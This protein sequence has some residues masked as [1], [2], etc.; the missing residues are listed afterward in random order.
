MMFSIVIPIYN[1]KKYLSKCLDSILCQIY[2]DFEC[3]LVDDGSTD[4][5]GKLCEHYKEKDKRIIVIHKEN[6]GAQ[7]AR[8]EGTKMAKG[9]YIVLI[10]AD[11]WVS[12]KLLSEINDILLE[13][14]PD[15]LC[16]D[17][18][19]VSDDNI[20]EKNM[21]IRQGFYNRKQIE[22]KLMYK[23]IRSEKGEAFTT[24]LWGK[25]FKRE[26]Y[27]KMQFAVPH[28]VIMG[29]D[30]CVMWPSVY[31]ANSIYYLRKPLYYYRKNASSISS[32]D[33]KKEGQSWD[34][35]VKINDYLRK[36]LPQNEYDFEGQIDRRIVIM[37]FTTALSWLCTGRSYCEIK[38]LITEN[39][40]RSEFQQMISRCKFKGNI[41]LSLL[42]AAVKH[43]LVWAVWIYK[44]ML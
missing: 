43:R 17:Y 37:L 18:Y 44:K 26:L 2:S 19:M 7:S 40:K 28:G 27:T 13:Y 21:N 38:K 32:L 24:S 31:N 9:E 33:R 20:V 16:H 8:I 3:I 36:V 34:N 6:G 22:D 14:N 11:D 10:D 41:K 23:C 35:I 15:I 39:F 30:A 29:E 4:G 12:E 42:A 1:T 25:A 5:S